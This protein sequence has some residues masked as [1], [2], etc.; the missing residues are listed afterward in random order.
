MKT[1]R[2][3]LLV[4]A[5]L[6]CCTAQAQNV[7]VINDAGISQSELD[8]VTLRIKD[9]V[10]DFVTYLGDLVN[11]KISVGAKESILETT[12]DLFIGSGKP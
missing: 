8:A 6:F 10:G 9:K 5:M 4:A 7:N 12:L 2:I 3:A 11:S 1:Q